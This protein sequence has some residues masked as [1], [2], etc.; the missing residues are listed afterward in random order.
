LI[1]SSVLIILSIGLFY[2]ALS[3]VT[4]LGVGSF[5]GSGKVLT[6]IPGVSEGV[7]VSCSWGPGIGFYLAILTLILLLIS[8]FFKK[9]ID[10]ALNKD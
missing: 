1:L 8:T 5:M 7:L 9:Q 3:L 2:Y 4:E 6:T 10:Q